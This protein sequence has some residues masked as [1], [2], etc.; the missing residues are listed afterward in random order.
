MWKEIE[1]KVQERE[2]L[3]LEESL[4]LFT[5][6]DIH[7][8]GELAHAIR[9][10][11]NGN[12]VF[13][14]KNRHVNPTNIC[15]YHCTFCSFRR[16]SQDVDAYL[17]TPYEIVEK[18]KGDPTLNGDPGLS[19][20]HIVGGMPPA[21]IAS[22]EYYRSVVKALKE[23]F[24]SACIKAFTAVEY[25]W[26]ADITGR[27]YEDILLDFKE[28]GLEMLPGGG[29]EIFN[30]DVRRRLCPEKCTGEQWLQIHKTA[31]R[32]GIKSNATMLYGHVEEPIHKAEHL[33]ALFDLQEET[34][35]FLAFIPLAYHP[36]NNRLRVKFFTSGCA[37]LRHISAS[38][39]ILH[40]FPHIKAYWIEFGLELAQLMLS[41]GA[42][43]LDGTIVE[44]H[45]YHDAGAKTPQGLTLEYLCSLI[46]EV[47]LKP[48]L[49]DALYNELALPSEVLAK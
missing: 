14:V 6:A 15:A 21:E 28:I 9:T 13:I 31:H 32:L 34:G 39:I 17:H 38:R 42:D 8:L 18:L 43:D 19:E 2:R 27:S 41:Y 46:E 1:K 26:F 45:I 5:D 44:E 33:L 30:W 47:G 35:G 3:T 4:Y 23:A 49:R 16:D 12:K 11:K 22:Y 48:V 40:N 10:E 24:P 37:D 25:Q 36:E 29:A 20:I 7:F